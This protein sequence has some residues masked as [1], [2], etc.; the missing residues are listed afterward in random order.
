MGSC[1]SILRELFIYEFH[2]GWLEWRHLL[3][4]FR[5]SK[6]AHWQTPTFSIL[7]LTHSHL[8]LYHSIRKWVLHN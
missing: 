7:K 6:M 2:V 8:F 1:Y 5:Y 4:A 3:L